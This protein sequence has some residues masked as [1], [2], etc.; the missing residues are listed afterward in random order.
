MRKTKLYPYHLEE[1]MKRFRLVA[2]FAAMAMVLASS[3]LAAPAGNMI[4]KVASFDFLVDQSGS[5]MMKNSA[6]SMYKNTVSKTDIAKRALVRVNDKIPQ[7]NYAGS[8]HTFAPVGEV[9]PLAPYNKGAMDKAIKSLKGDLN[10]YDRLTPMGDGINRLAPVYNN[11]ARKTAVIIVTDGESNIGSDPVAEVNNIYAVNPDICIHFISVADTPEGK[12]T[13]E[14]A[15][16]L[17][18]CSVV[19][20]AATLNNNDAAVDKFVQDVFYDL[21]AHSNLVLRSVQFALNS[22]VID[23]PSAAIL[24]EVASILKKNPGHIQIDGHTCSLGSAEYN[25]KLSQ[26]RADA[27]KAYLVHKGIPASSLSTTG[28]GLTRP[29]FDN[30]KDEGRRLNRRAELSY[31]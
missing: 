4:P 30:S 25:M 29:K 5:M 2:L 3:A 12:K 23:A 19:A 22:A 28:Y 13:I 16:A 18:K 15:A 21:G 1:L 27:V 11:M 8:L 9:L 26:H 7:L 6:V 17:R 10:I 20:E 24:D 31:R 14:R